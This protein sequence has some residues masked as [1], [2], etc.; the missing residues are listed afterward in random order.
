[1]SGRIKLL[2]DGVA[3]QMADTPELGYEYDMP[4]GHDIDCG[5][6]GLDNFQLPHLECP[7][8]F[9][10]DSESVNGT[11]RQLS[12]CIDSMN[13]AMMA[14]MTSSVKGSADPTALFI[15]Q[16]IPHHQNA[17]K[18]KWNWSKQLLDNEF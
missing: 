1:M 10:C 8:R 15:H 9:V 7:D 18:S 6:Y 16:M 2:N 14:G 11:L 17:G 12:Q 5:T 3:M 4:I 13:C